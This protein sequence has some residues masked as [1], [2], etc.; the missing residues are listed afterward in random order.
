M[1]QQPGDS[2]A[3]STRKEGIPE[4][5]WMRCPECGDMLFR[6]VVSEALHVCPHC[7]HHFRIAART[8]IEELVDTGS[9]EEMLTDG[10]PADRLKFT[11]RKAY[12]HRLPDEQAKTGNP[13]EVVRG[14]RF[15]KARP[16]L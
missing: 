13:A 12:N 11:G 15:I 14:R 16:V 1:T 6:K 10:E 3:A 7:Q 2:T 8:R 4:G 9:Y 5:L